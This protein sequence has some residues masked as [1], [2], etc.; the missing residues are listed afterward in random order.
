MARAKEIAQHFLLFRVHADHGFPCLKILLLEFGDVFKLFV[1]VRISAHAD[2][3][4]RLAFGEIKLVQ[5]L[6]DYFC[7]HG[8]SQLAE[9]VRDFLSCQ[10]GPNDIALHRITGYVLPHDFNEVVLK[11]RHRD[12]SFLS[13]PLFYGPVQPLDHLEA[14]RHPLYPV[15]SY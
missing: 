7:A 2:A 12:A 15:E 5:E 6:S 10:T 1:P 8:S 4:L 3:L 9:A 11:F 14:V 13:A